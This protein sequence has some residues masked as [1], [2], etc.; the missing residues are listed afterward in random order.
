MS[1]SPSGNASTATARPPSAA[2]AQIPNCTNAYLKF[3]LVAG[4]DWQ[5]LDGLEEG[6]TQAA[7]VAEGEGRG[8]VGGKG[9]DRASAALQSGGTASECALSCCRV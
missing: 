9:T 7:R 5:L 1:A 2:A 8:G 6:I 3:Q 4:E